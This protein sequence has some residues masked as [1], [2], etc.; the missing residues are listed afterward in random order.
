MQNPSAMLDIVMVVPVRPAVSEA[1]LLPPP[2]LLLV[3]VIFFVL[4]TTALSDP[5]PRRS[6]GR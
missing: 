3:L 6:F 5:V 2:E 4:L 1:A